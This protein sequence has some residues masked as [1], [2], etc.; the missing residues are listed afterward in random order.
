M[1]GEIK[2]EEPIEPATKQQK[3]KP[4]SL[5][6]NPPGKGGQVPKKP[7]SEPIPTTKPKLSPEKQQQ[8]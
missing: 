4:A 6:I 8:K 5:P 7:P 1:N 2:R 3:P